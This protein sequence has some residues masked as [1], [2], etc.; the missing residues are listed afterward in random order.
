M[1]AHSPQ[2][3]SW[4]RWPWWRPRFRRRP[5]GSA[6]HPR[7]RSSGLGSR[8]CPGTHTADTGCCTV[9]LQYTRHALSTTHYTLSGW[10]LK[11]ETWGSRLDL[12]CVSNLVRSTSM[13]CYSYK[14]RADVSLHNNLGNKRW[15]REVT[16]SVLIVISV[17]AIRKARPVPT[18]SEFSALLKLYCSI[19]Y[20][21]GV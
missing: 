13:S 19:Q 14:R 11:K 6:A 2:R 9:A 17:A 4:R 1:F 15:A 10:I 20:E 3:T 8:T 18:Y 16:R 5:P 12:I 7:I 21:C